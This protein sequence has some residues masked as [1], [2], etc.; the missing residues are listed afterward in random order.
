MVTK[1]D[2]LGRDLL[3]LQVI[4]NQIEEKGAS[5]TVLDQHVDTST[6]AGK[7]FF[8]MLGVFAEFEYGIRKERQMVGIS[9]AKA[10][11]KYQGKA[12]SRD[13]DQI[14][15]LYAEGE[16]PAHIARDLGIG[17]TTVYRALG[18]VRD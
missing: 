11:G 5:L 6:A 16:K 13:D 12:K 10:E 3:D 14:K 9:K 15:K 2:R 17:R 8:Q 18:N 4:C 7:A 1:L